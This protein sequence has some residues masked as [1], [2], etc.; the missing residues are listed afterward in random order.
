MAWLQ[1]KFQRSPLMLA[2]DSRL[3]VS[4]AQRIKR[5]SIVLSLAL[6]CGFLLSRR[7]WLSTRDYPLTPVAD[8]LPALRFPLDHLAFALLLL[9]PVGIIVS[10]RP[11]KL[12]SL[13]VTLI[14]LLMLCDQS[15]WQPWCY[16]YVFMLLAL[17]CY[18]WRAGETGREAEAAAETLDACRLIVAAVYFW[19]GLHKINPAFIRELFPALLEPYVRYLPETLRVTAYWLA[20]FVPLAEVG[21]GVGLLSRRYR[22]PAIYLALALHASILILFV[23]VRRNVVIWPW[24]VAMACFAVILFRRAGHSMFPT[25][26]QFL[27]GR[28][29]LLSKLILVLFGVAPFLNFFGYWNAYLSSSLYS[30]KTIYGYVDVS[31]EVRERLPPGARSYVRVRG[32]GQALVDVTRWSFGELN[33]PP[34]PAERVYKNVAHRICAHATRPSEVVLEIHGEP[35]LFSRTRNVERYD[36]ASL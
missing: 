26:R 10:A 31:A 4:P 20:P 33:V 9:L 21:V 6:L 24:N 14:M 25:L 13:F 1:E 36:C 35:G 7:L 2:L 12:L 32:D 3:N 30:G 5:L 29:Q 17:A 16:Q 19:S 22:N 11:R 28:R 18:S 27:V 23:P 34:Y 8:F 15:R